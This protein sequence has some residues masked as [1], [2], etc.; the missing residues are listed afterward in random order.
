MDCMVKVRLSLEGFSH[1][2]FLPWI[3]FNICKTRLENSSQRAYTVESQ[4]G[5]TAV[6]TVFLQVQPAN[7][8]YLLDPSGIAQC[9]VIPPFLF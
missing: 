1:A 6:V 7:L 2:N 3:G 9:M 4:P 8:G 5:L